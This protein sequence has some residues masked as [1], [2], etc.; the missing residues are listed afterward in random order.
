[1]LRIT[2]ITFL[3]IILITTLESCATLSFYSQAIVGQTSLLW[4]RKDIN[5]IVAD[6]AT[7]EVTRNK[8]L[9]VLSVLDYAQD[10]L[11][12]PVGDSFS[13]YVATGKPFILWNVFAA[14]ELSLEMKSFCYPIAGCVS[15]R[16]YFKERQALNMA[17]SLQNDGYDVFVGGVAAYSTLGWFSDPVLDTFLNRSDVNI[18]RL[19]FHELAHK[20]IYIPGDTQFN[21]S[22]ATAVEQAA[23]KPWLIDREQDELYKDYVAQGKRRSQ[24][25]RIINDTRG[26]LDV[27][28]KSELSTANQRQEKQL[29]IHSLRA[30]Y[31]T[32]RKSWNGEYDFQYWMSSEIPFSE[33]NNAK[34]GTIAEYNDWVPAFHALLSDHG[35]DLSEFVE[36]VDKISKL[37]R[38]ARDQLLREKSS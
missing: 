21:E 15:Y 38:E 24:V 36:A 20:A 2:S 25:L 32:L 37:E 12:L 27:L 8:L 3:I 35:G 9:L 18:A 34:L 17:S 22:F 4:H 5:S 33:I 14:P 31:Q 26:A 6:P 10:N 19:L 28:Y 11:N 13:T 23:I 16:G 7:D 29:L 30:E 1:M